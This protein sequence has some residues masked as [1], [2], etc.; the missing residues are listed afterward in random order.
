MRGLCV[1]LAGLALGC[2]GSRARPSGPPPEYEAPRVTPWDAG[3]APADEF[4][5]AERGGEPV[6]DGDEPT[7]AD[8]GKDALPPAE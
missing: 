4:S 3:A 8:A 5:E 6:T 7:S 2:S 1:V